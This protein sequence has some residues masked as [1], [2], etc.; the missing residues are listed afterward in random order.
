MKLVLAI[1]SGIVFGIITVIVMIILAIPLVIV[2]VVVGIAAA[3]SALMWNAVTITLA[4][5]AGCICFALLFYLIALITVPVA[6]FFPA[7]SIHFLASRYPGLDA[8]LH[9]APP[10]PPLPPVPYIPPPFSPPEPN[11]IG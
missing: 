10:A 9:P 6:V 2:G 3:K 4:V 1:A 11:A 8:L 5:V 7:Y